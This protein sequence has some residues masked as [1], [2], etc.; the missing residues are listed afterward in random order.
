MNYNTLMSSDAVI[1]CTDAEGKEIKKRLEQA[2]ENGL[3]H[4]IECELDST[5]IY[6][7]AEE[8][9]CLDELPDEVIEMV[10]KLLA[11]AKMKYVTF[12]MAFT[13][14]RMAPDSQGGTYA[15]ILANGTMVWP[16]LVWPKGAE[17]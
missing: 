4:G 13:S 17:D 9:A 8:S 6:F 14:S 12:Q 2:T 11:K 16:K 15:R 5:G 1:P 3:Y 7:F 10:G